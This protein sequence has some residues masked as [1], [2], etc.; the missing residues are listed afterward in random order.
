MIQSYVI[1]FVCN[2]WKINDFLYI[3]TLVSSSNIGGHQIDI[4]LKVVLDILLTCW[5]SDKRV[6]E[7]TF[8]E[9]KFAVIK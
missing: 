4:L 2:L 1:K 6:G 5:D 7:E 8:Q 9:T 3:G